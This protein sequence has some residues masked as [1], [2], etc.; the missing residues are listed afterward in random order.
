[1]VE[2]VAAKP[3][4]FISSTPGAT[5]DE[6]MFIS[7]AKSA[8]QK[9]ATNSPVSSALLQL[10]LRSPLVQKPMTGGVSAKALKKL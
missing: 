7:W 6:V 10:S 8:P 5:D 3:A 9:L 2:A 1:M 4:S